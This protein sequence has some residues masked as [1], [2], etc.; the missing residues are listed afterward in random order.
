MQ[1]RAGRFGRRNS[2]VVIIVSLVME[3]GQAALGWVSAEMMGSRRL[4][5]N[6]WLRSQPSDW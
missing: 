4:L 3:L 5:R 6:F 2:G 1:S